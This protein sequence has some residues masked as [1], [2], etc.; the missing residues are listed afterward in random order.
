M[1]KHTA[2]PWEYDGSF[3]CGYIVKP[4][5]DH[6]DIYLFEGVDCD[7]EGLFV[8]NEEERNANGRLAAA[9]PE[10]FRLLERV[11]R[12]VSAQ[13]YDPLPGKEGMLLAEI[14]ATIAEVKGE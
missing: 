14:R 8:D 6:G 2:A 7:S 4:M 11:E 9:A 1:S 10:M 5:E 13:E 3:G 12:F